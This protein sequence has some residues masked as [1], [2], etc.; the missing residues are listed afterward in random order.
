MGLLYIL[1]IE[2]EAGWAPGPVKTLWIGSCTN[3]TAVL[4]L[5]IICIA[6]KFLMAREVQFP[7]LLRYVLST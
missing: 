6:K 2:Y 7:L 4:N 5:N 3:P 1:P